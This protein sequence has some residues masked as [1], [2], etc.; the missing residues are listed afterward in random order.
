MKI[1]QSAKWQTRES[2]TAR[3]PY[4]ASLSVADGARVNVADWLAGQGDA[5]Y[6]DGNG[7]IVVGALGG[8]GEIAASCVKLAENGRLKMAVGEPIGLTV[9][10]AL[11]L[12]TNAVVEITGNLM[13]LECGLYPLLSCASV[14][15]AQ[16]RW[17]FVAP[18]RPKR[19]FCVLSAN[20]TLTL[21]VTACGT[22]ILL[23]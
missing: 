22:T 21:S 12:P 18:T 2:P 7:D 5:R 4:C 16:T 20:G 9:T 3:T 6:G 10:G 15:G 23:R 11:E 1:I 14:T 19:S 13:D 17:T 8:D